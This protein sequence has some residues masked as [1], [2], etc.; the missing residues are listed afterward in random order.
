MKTKILRKKKLIMKNRKIWKDSLSEN[1]KILKLY[2]INNS[3][4]LMCSPQFN[5][6]FK[7][8]RNLLKTIRID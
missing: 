6:N 4:L 3:Y 8:N 1:N 7:L 2:N 5:K